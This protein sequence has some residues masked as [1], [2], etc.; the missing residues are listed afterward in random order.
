[1]N[2]ISKHCGARSDLGTPHAKM[3]E[4]LSA[5]DLCYKK[6]PFVIS[7]PPITFARAGACSDRRRA[8]GL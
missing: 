1:M 2:S 6:G 4:A 7:F 3:S 5:A 8:A